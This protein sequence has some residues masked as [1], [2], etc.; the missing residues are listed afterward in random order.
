MLRAHDV[1]GRRV[2]EVARAFGTSRQALYAAAAAFQAQGIPGL[3]P[4]PRGPKR[5]HKCTDEILDFAEQWQAAE[6]P[7]ERSVV[8]AIHRRFGVTIHPRSLQRALARRT[9]KGAGKGARRS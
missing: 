6:T 4:R 5:A 2:S 9:K 7:E 8:D 1:D 3:L